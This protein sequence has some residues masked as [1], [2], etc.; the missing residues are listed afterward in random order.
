MVFFVFAPFPVTDAFASFLTGLSSR[1]FAGYRRFLAG[2]PGNNA[3]WYVQDT[4]KVTRRFTVNAGVRAMN[5][6]NHTPK[7]TTG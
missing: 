5:C 4:Y 2:I 3:N 1:L 7:F 6:P